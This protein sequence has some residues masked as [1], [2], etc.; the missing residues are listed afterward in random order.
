MISLI[1]YREVNFAT[2][3]C[4]HKMD[5]KANGYAKQMFQKMFV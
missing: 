4:V 2:D 5:V 1:L 3:L